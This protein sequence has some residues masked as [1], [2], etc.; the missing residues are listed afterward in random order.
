MTKCAPHDGKVGAGLDQAMREIVSQYMW[1]HYLQALYQIE[2][3]TDPLQRCDCLS[4]SPK[5][6]RRLMR[7]LLHHPLVDAGLQRICTAQVCRPV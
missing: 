5:P 6:L 2:H 7:T 1:R 4:I 3:H